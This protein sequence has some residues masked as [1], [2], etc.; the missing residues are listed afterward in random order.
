VR[1]TLTNEQPVL[2]GDGKP[3]LTPI[4]YVALASL[5]LLHAGAVFAATDTINFPV[6]AGADD[7]FAWGGATQDTTAG[8]LMVGD[9]RDYAAPYHMSAMRFIDVNIPRGAPV[10]AA[11]LD[12]RSV[13]DG[14][15]GQI[16]GVIQ[17][18][19]ADDAAYF[20][21]RYIAAAARTIAS[22]DWD[23]K[24]NWA[25]DT[26]YSS[27]D[28]A[29]V[30]QEVV[31]RGG[32]SPGNSLA[33]FYSTRADSG[34]DRKFGS[35]ELGSG[36]AA[37]LSITFETYIISG[38]VKTADA[39]GMA[40]V[41]ASAGAGVGPTV[42]DGSGY[43]ELTVPGG[44]TGTV[45]PAKPDWGFTPTSWPY[46]NVTSDQTNQ[47]YTGF[48][49]TI[50]GYVTDGG[51]GVEGV[52]VSGNNGGGSDVTD[53]S[54]YYEITVPHGWTGTITPAKTGWSFT[55][56][57]LPYGNVTA[58]YPNQNYTGFQPTISG[59][60]TGDSGVSGVTVSANNGGGSDVTD[61][62]G[63]YEI[64][65]P[66]GW[67]GTV[68]AAKTGWLLT[69]ANRS[70]TNVTSDWTNRDYTA[71]QPTIWGYVTDGADPIEGV[72]LSAD[73][74]GGSDTTD[75][76]G[77]YEI[78]VAYNW[79]GTITPS[80]AGWLITPVNRSYG[81]VT[82]DYANQ[83]YTGFQ[84]TISGTITYNSAGLEGVTVAADNGGGTDVTN[85][86]GYYEIT[87]AYNWSGAVTPAK[88]NWQFDPNQ[89]DYMNVTSNA[90]GQDYDAAYF[91]YGGGSG[92]AA[93]P[94]IIATAEHMNEIGAY[95]TNWDKHFLL[96]SDIDLAGFTGTQFNVIGIDYSNAFTGVFDGNGRTISN[97]TYDS[98]GVDYI[99][100]FGYV[101]DSAAQIKNLGLIDPN[102]DAR[103]GD[104][105][106]GLIG[107]LYYNATVSDCYVQ[108]GSISGD[109]HIG[110]LVGYSSG[111]ISRCYST[112][113][114]HGSNDYVGGLV[115]RS[116]S[117][118]VDCYAG[119]DVSG[120]S[121]VGGLV[122]TNSHN[123]IRC[124][125]TGGVSGSSETG[126]LA[127]FNSDT[128]ISCYWDTQTSG[129]TTSSGGAGRTTAQMQSADTYINWGD[130]NDPVW[131][132][133][134]GNDYPRQIWQGTSGQVICDQISDYLSGNGTAS[135]PYLIYT[136]E[137]LNTIGLFGQDWDKHFRLMA[138][139]DLVALAQDRFNIIGISNAF[140]G[141]FDGNGH[142][143]SNFTLTEQSS[144]HVGLFGFVDDPNAEI[145]NLGLIDPNVSGF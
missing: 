32:W 71:F 49:P 13:S 69:P 80:K 90:T 101:K 79:S 82:A 108:G 25:T 81:N 85:A 24:T 67:S 116:S 122:G 14:T 54:G 19:A 88:T 95:P 66:Y 121:Y 45:T 59:Y 77:Y 20:S 56:A 31:D 8:Y 127:G 93:E 100:L 105:V 113:D 118:M 68:T 4:A 18:E 84:P 9:G 5:I 53:S 110:G 119:G 33:V 64:T 57:S 46:T 112:A 87:V 89:L 37:V 86:S 27:G 34:K 61:A 115:G 29:G 111:L 11:H 99:G 137:Q 1:R 123:I 96:V 102:V 125:S 132:I 35:F 42:T 106:G 15:R 36:Y 78:V 97:F 128:V 145:R 16:Y 74:G 50:S 142:T 44:W 3:G 52:T 40:G 55:P 138:D 131:R 12:I 139:I 6:S 133:D 38:Y 28:L 94:F 75:A 72:S 144:D 39:V 140:T 30:I 70:Y 83:N 65:V 126:G 130:C 124:Y 92:T 22:V 10:V 21:S 98:N 109:R 62:S 41:T 129:Q 136:A 43:Y 103:T 73:N 63:Y 51:S 107:H 58:D 135:Q 143:I 76:N 2:G 48:Q 141:F 60:V 114:V 17:A 134:D 117:D 26:L 47:D 23:H 104:Y 91:G 7:G 120:N